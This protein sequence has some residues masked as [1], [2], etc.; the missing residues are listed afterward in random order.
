[1][2]I[3]FLPHDVD[4]ASPIYYYQENFEA[5]ERLFPLTAEYI[6]EVELHSVI[7]TDGTIIPID[8][9]DIDGIRDALTDD[10]TVMTGLG[11]NSGILPQYRDDSSVWIYPG[12]VAHRGAF[13]VQ[14]FDSA[15]DLTRIVDVGASLYD[16]VADATA[17]GTTGLDADTR[18]YGYIKMDVAS[19]FPEY[20]WSKQPPTY[21]AGYGPEHPA[22]TAN[23]RFFGSL[24]TGPLP[25]AAIIPHHR[26]GDG[27]VLL[28]DVIVGPSE[29]T[30][31]LLTGDTAGWVAKSLATVVPPTAD[32]VFLT[33]Q[34]DS[35]GAADSHIRV[36]AI[37]DVATNSG[38]S[39]RPTDPEESDDRIVSTAWMEVPINTLNIDTDEFR[40]TEVEINV[41][42]YLDDARVKDRLAVAGYRERLT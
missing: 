15:T 20:R 36:R 38:F 32:T 18:Y 25:D 16:P 8:W 29:S 5:I 21:A 40:A 24:L 34:M 33:G 6:D 26:Y 4:P 1:M 27:R 3:E 11:F 2:T 13:K 31:N 39:L 10:S 9:L 37:G 17:P 35:N 19:A 7:N 14:P 22:D 28:R 41:T 42:G 23:Y 30:D 12:S